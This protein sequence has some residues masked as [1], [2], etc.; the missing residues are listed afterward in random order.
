MHQWIHSN[1]IPTPP[2]QRIGKV[3]VRLW[4]EKDVEKVKK[5]K[6]SRYW[7]RAVAQ[8]ESNGPTDVAGRV[9]VIST[10]RHHFTWM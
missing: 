8:K 10:E 9:D 5:Y 3:S 6:T 1:V 2:V 4:T 7:T